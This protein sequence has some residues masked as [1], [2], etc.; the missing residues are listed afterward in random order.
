MQSLHWY[1]CNV[2]IPIKDTNHIYHCNHCSDIFFYGY[3]VSSKIDNVTEGRTSVWR[4]PGSQ[5]L[6]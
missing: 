1:E 4:K 6:Y 3:N 2:N 5:K